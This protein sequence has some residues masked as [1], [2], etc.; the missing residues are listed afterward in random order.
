MKT[1][2]HMQTIVILNDSYIA[3]NNN[4][5]LRICL[6][7]Y[8]FC[9]CQCLSKI[10]KSA[11]REATKA[12]SRTAETQGKNKYDFMQYWLKYPALLG[13][14]DKVKEYE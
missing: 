10:K 13:I 3:V 5:Q 14:Q 1:A 9:W 11:A 7:G 4:P 8:E 2:K 6:D 12:L